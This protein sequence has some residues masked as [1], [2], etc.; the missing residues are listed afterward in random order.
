MRNGVERG[1]RAEGRKVKMVRLLGAALNT[2]IINVVERR[3]LA[4]LS[5]LFK[6]HLWVL[7]REKSGKR[8]T[9][10]GHQ[11]DSINEKLSW[12]KRG[13]TGE[14]ESGNCSRRGR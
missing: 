1:E 14:G 3:A 5:L 13:H 4:Q 12:K 9:G 6:D 10:T 8:E 7:G 2:G 11:S